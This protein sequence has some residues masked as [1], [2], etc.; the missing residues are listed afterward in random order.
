[1]DGIGSA[2]R[3]YAPSSSAMDS[4]GNLYI[5]DSANYTIRKITPGGVVTTFAGTPGVSASVDGT[6][7]SAQ[8]I[9]PKGVAVDRAGIV[10][11][12]D[13]NTIRKITP[14]GA[15]TTFAGT[16]RQFGGADGTGAAARFRVPAGLAV[17][18]AGTVFVA[19][20]GNNVIRRITPA[21]VVTTLAGTAP[22]S[23][24]YSPGSYGS[25]LSTDGTGPASRFN[26][27]GG[28]A[29]DNL[30]NVFVA[31]SGNN[32][33]RKIT[34][35]GVVSTL[36][37][38]GNG[39][40]DGTG[41]A[42]HFDFPSGIAVD[43]A[44]NS[45]VADSANFTIR[46]ITPAGLVTTLAGTARILGSANGTGANAQFNFPT[47]LAVDS[48]GEILVADS[49]NHALRK[50]AP[51][52]IVT[53]FAGDRRPG[54]GDCAT[55]RRGSVIRRHSER[56]EGAIGGDGNIAAIGRLADG[57]PGFRL[58]DGC[59]RISNCERLDGKTRAGHRELRESG[60]YAQ[61]HG[62]FFR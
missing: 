57:R 9:L 10:Y 58:G 17:D 47:A 7:T 27:P 16:P 36:A 24:G 8:F 30:G 45:Y 61:P 52:N 4:T 2:A 37:G 28:V 33:I 59:C 56:T 53:T 55:A 13:E 38:N 43:S 46:K 51:G 31:D 23:P 44:G 22:D 25:G 1:M 54:A 39:S 32:K 34:S 26:I 18:S 62:S 41:I 40:A 48:A 5:A 15:V 11:V 50:I 49:L 60:Q 42:A 20:Y 35:A 19:D 6:G 12:S 21:G 29:V 14:G 3:F